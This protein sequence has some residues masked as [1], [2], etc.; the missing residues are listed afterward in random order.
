MKKLQKCRLMR[1][2]RNAFIGIRW[3]CATQYLSSEKRT[4]L[5]QCGRNSEKEQVHG[6]CNQEH[7]HDI[8]TE[9]NSKTK[10]L[11]SSEN[12]PKK[13]NSTP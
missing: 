11:S 13:N 9:I 1:R 10:Q 3:R 2:R 6:R 7:I 4:L 12:T 8:K 5:L